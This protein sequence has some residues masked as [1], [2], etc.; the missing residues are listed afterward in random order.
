MIWEDKVQGLSKKPAFSFLDSPKW[1]KVPLIC[2]D[3]WIVDQKNI[4]ISPQVGD[5]KGAAYFLD[6]PCSLLNRPSGWYRIRGIYY[7]DWFSCFVNWA[8][9][10]YS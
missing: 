9:V 10:D 7:R 5:N 3:L 8:V 1:E 4:K 6:S 2:T